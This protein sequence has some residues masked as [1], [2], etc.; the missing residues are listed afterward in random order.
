MKCEYAPRFQLTWKKLDF[1]FELHSKTYVDSIA[2]DG[3]ET[4]VSFQSGGRG[5]GTSLRASLVN[6]STFTKYSQ[7]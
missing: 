5:K 4:S 2:R 1:A 3:H 6:S 7:S